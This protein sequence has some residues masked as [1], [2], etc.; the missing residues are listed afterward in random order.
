MLDDSLGVHQRKYRGQVHVSPTPRRRCRASHE[1]SQ[2]IETT[3][4]DCSCVADHRQRPRSPPSAPLHS[5]LAEP[6]TCRSLRRADLAA[7]GL[8]SL[9]GGVALG[10]RL[11]PRGV[12]ARVGQCLGDVVRALLGQLLG[13]RCVRVAGVGHHGHRCVRSLHRGGNLLQGLAVLAGQV[14]TLWGERDGVRPQYRL[15]SFTE[16]TGCL[17]QDILCGAGRLAASFLGGIARL[18]ARVLSRT[19]R[20]SGDILGTRASGKP[21]QYHR[22]RDNPE[23][24]SHHVNTPPLPTPLSVVLATR[25]RSDRPGTAVVDSTGHSLE[26]GKPSELQETRS[27]RAIATARKSLNHPIR[28]SFAHDDAIPHNSECKAESLRRGGRVLP[29]YTAGRLRAENRPPVQLG[30]AMQAPCDTTRRCWLTLRVRLSSQRPPPAFLLGS[31]TTLCVDDEEHDQ[32]QRL[33][34]AVAVAAA[35]SLTVLG[36]VTAAPAPAAAVTLAAGDCPAGTTP[37]QG[38]TGCIPS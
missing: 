32:M 16:C 10:L 36:A 13:L 35:L 5:R 26:L 15:D 2:Q 20:L 11:D 25:S 24:R 8:V 21:G 18:V 12:R 31:V 33:F 28:D 27:T 38:G 14:R 29:N 3:R 17:I 19:T 4:K 7:Q 37:V 23:T 34:A 22:G 1:Q 6:N 9:R 30:N